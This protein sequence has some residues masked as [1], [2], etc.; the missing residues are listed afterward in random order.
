MDFSFLAQVE[1]SFVVT[2]LQGDGT[3]RVFPKRGETT[4]TATGR[5]ALPFLSGGAGSVDV[6]DARGSSAYA[7][8]PRPSTI[9][10][11]PFP[12]TLKSTKSADAKS[13]FL[14]LWSGDFVA[15]WSILGSATAIQVTAK[16]VPGVSDNQFAGEPLLVVTFDLGSRGDGGRFTAEMVQPQLAAQLHES[17]KAVLAPRVLHHFLRARADMLCSWST[18]RSWKMRWKPSR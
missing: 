6:L 10:P 12:R 2:D 17:A 13:A 4:L 1:D 14:K 9:P 8:L 3:P 7:M 18:Q 11:Q 15:L 16:L 5:V